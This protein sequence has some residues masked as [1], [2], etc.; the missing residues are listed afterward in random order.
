MS[1]GEGGTIVGEECRGRECEGESGWML[2]VS[3]MK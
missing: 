3:D 2:Y 1:E